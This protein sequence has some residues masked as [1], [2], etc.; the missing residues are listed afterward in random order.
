MS[1]NAILVGRDAMLA[2][3]LKL[4]VIGD[5]IANSNTVGY[6]GRRVVF[7]DRLGFYTGSTWANGLRS[8]T[9]RGVMIGG[10]TT[11]WTSGVI[12]DTG[13]ATHLA[14]SGEGMLPVQLNGTTYYTRTGDFTMVET[15]PNT[16]EYQLMR[17][18]G[19]VLMGGTADANGVVTLSGPVTITGNP[20]DLRFT[21]DGLVSATGATVT[22]GEI[23]IQR[24]ANPDALTRRGMGLYETTELSGPAGQNPV[25]PGS[26]GGGT[27]VQG[28]LEQSNVDLVNE[29]SELIITQRA[30][31]ANSRTI[32][33]ANEMLQEVLNIKR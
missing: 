16:G 20:S 11:D 29:F 26:D 8:S 10:G 6:K 31:Q 17:A 7:A 19:S 3:T 2:Q 12:G 27:L 21:Q 22:N 30:Y 5:N 13:A 32:T 28:A 33:T 15:G 4:N 9:G 1:T 14:I 25:K 18:D 24:F 23:G